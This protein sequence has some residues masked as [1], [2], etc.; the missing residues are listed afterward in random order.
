MRPAYPSAHAAMPGA[1]SAMSRDGTGSVLRGEVAFFSFI[2]LASST[3]FFQL[4]LASTSSLSAIH[5]TS[6]A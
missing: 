1:I 5:G 3:S 6:H 4:Y 2:Y